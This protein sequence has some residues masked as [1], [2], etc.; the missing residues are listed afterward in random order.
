MDHACT[1]TTWNNFSYIYTKVITE[2]CK[3]QCLN[4]SIHC[5]LVWSMQLQNHIK[6]WQKKPN[7]TASTQQSSSRDL[8]RLAFDESRLRWWPVDNV[9]I[10][11]ILTWK[12]YL[13]AAVQR[14]RKKITSIDEA[15]TCAYSQQLSKKYPQTNQ[16]K[17]AN[18]TFSPFSNWA[19]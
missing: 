18:R 14:E 11:V 1:R 7:I 16:E 10:T 19:S 8:N 13:S 9:T 17:P 5:S 6:Q 15:L 2:L 3:E 12:W 4:H